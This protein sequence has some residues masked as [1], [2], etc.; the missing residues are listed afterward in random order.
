V[1]NIVD[2]TIKQQATQYDLMSVPSEGVD[3][4]ITELLSS[5][6]TIDINNLSP[7]Q[8]LAKLSELQKNCP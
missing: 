5:L 6:K 2:K 4:K 1:K 7:L 8:A 3:P